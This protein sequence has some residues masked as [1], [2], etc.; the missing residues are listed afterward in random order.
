MK[1]RI[2]YAAWVAGVVQFLVVHGIVESAWTNP[3]SWARNNISDLGNAHCAMQSDPEPRY[4][5]SPEHVLMNASFTALGALIVV[6]VAFTGVLWRTGAIS[7]AARC[8]LACAGVGFALAGLAPADVH[9]NQHLLGALFIMAMGNIV[10]LPTGHGRLTIQ[11]R[12]MSV[13]T[14]RPRPLSRGHP[15]R[16]VNGIRARTGPREQSHRGEAWSPGRGLRGR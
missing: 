12:E 10:P 16:P 8:L 9:E 14:H 7:T 15:R 3:Y 1:A 13:W 11:H 2:G 5:C 4:I 6:G